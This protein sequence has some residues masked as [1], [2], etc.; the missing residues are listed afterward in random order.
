MDQDSNEQIG[1]LADLSNTGMML[2][3]H[4]QIQ[5][6]TTIDSYIMLDYQAE[7]GSDSF[8]EAQIQTCWVRPNINHDMFCVGCKILKIDSKSEKKLRET[9]HSLGFD[10]ELEISRVSRHEDSEH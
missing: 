6:N 3:T 7:D 10:S 5:P 8:V 9:A 1:Y 4:I 2:I